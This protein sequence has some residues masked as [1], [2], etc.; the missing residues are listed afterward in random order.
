MHSSPD[1]DIDPNFKTNASVEVSYQWEVT[2]TNGNRA[3]LTIR[4]QGPLN[5]GVP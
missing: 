2:D 4:F 1:T 3:L 5:K